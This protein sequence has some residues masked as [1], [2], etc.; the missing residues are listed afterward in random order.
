MNKLISKYAVTLLVIIIV[1]VSIS[2]TSGLESLPGGRLSLQYEFTAN[3]G[4]L[5]NFA[6]YD[7]DQETE[8][9]LSYEYTTLPSYIG[10]DISALM[11]QGNNQSDDLFMYAQNLV[12]GLLPNTEY[13][14]TLE[15]EFATNAPENSVGI[16]GSPG[17]SVFI[18]AGVMPFDPQTNLV[19]NYYEVNF[20]KGEQ[21]ESGTDVITY[22]TFG[23]SNSAEDTTYVLKKFN[24]KDNPIIMRSRNVGNIYIIIGTDSGFEGLTKIYYNR[25]VISLIA[26][27]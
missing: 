11:I 15:L 10:P 4:W 14:V 21:S 12:D 6:E 24:N 8:M 18:K 23:N 25:L 2:C 9:Q 16:G 27:N 22:G 13:E 3:E 20:D 1:S 17:S 19:N 7:K 26:L 5:V